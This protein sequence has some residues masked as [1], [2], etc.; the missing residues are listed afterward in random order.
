MD[1]RSD[2]PP[3]AL[4]RQLRRAGALLLAAAAAPDQCRVQTQGGMLYMR[5]GILTCLQGTTISNATAVSVA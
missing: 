3:L 2:A 1:Q 4:A 5:S